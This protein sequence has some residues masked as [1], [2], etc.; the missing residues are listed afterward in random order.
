L[1]AIDR[2]L[3]TILICATEENAIITFKSV[4]REQTNLVIAAPTIPS[5]IRTFIQ[6][7]FVMLINQ[8]NLSTPYPPIFN[9]TPAKIMEPSTGAST[10]AFGSQTCKKNTGSLA[11]KIKI[12]SNHNFE[13]IM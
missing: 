8:T 12:T 9:K 7:N 4:C 5:D 3:N 11:K 1:L 13:F 2:T 10:C 6:I